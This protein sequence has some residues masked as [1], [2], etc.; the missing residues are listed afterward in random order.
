[1]VAIR[2]P[3][4]TPPAPPSKINGWTVATIR[5]P[6]QTAAPVYYVVDRSHNYVGLL[7]FSEHKSRSLAVAW[8]ETHVDALARNLRVVSP[9]T[10][11]GGGMMF[12]D[13]IWQKGQAP[14]K[15][16]VSEGLPGWGE[17]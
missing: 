1:M 4:T 8:A 5:V 3:I 17:F 7:A 14:V 6:Q 12:F 11:D 10:A 15:R 13:D 16:P 2:S 9:P